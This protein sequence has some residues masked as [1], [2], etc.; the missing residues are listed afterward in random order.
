MLVAMTAL[1]VSLIAGP[2]ADVSGK[3]DGK[4]KAQRPDGTLHEDTVLLILTQKDK[5]ISGTVGGADHDQHPITSGSIDGN[6]VIILARNANNDREYKLELA[7][8]G[9]D[10]KGTISYGGRTAELA[11]KKRKP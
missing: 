1:F 8:D 11:V 2:A 10:M 3:W 5:T 4:L 6:T 9:D 7:I